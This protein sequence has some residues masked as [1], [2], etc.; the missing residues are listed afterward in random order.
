MTRHVVE[1]RANTRSS[2]FSLRG[3]MKV[4]AEP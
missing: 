2:A 4:G 3:V 1:P